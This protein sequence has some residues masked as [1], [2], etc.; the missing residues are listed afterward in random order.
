MRNQNV[1][2]R[3]IFSMN[4]SEYHWKKTTSCLSTSPIQKIMGQETEN[5]LKFLSMVLLFL[6]E[7]YM[8]M[9]MICSQSG[10]SHT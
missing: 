3:T 6:N 7:V 10:S 9:S 1:F 4:V 8:Q 2:F 5:Y